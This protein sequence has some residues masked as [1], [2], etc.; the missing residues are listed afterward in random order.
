VKETIPDARQK[1]CFDRFHVARYFT[2]AVDTVRAEEHRDYKAKYGTSP[3]TK[4]RYMRLRSKE[5]RAEQ[6]TKDFATL[7]R[8]SLNTARSWRIKESAVELWKLTDRRE[9]LEGWYRL[10]GW[11]ARCRLRPMI[12]VGRTI[13]SYLWG[14]LNATVKRATNAKLESVNAIIQKLKVRACEFHH[15][16]RFKIAILFHCGKLSMFPEGLT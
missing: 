10:L 6:S 14:I 13:R 5:T 15:R 11:T 8:M 3:L 4:T 9:S 7:S 2:K 1:I 12:E 16:A